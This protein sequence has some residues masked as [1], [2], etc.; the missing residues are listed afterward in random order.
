MR[1]QVVR[2]HTPADTASWMSRRYTRRVGPSTAC[3][4]ASALA[5]VRS[6]TQGFESGGLDVA[7]RRGTRDKWQKD[8]KGATLSAD[9]WKRKEKEKKR[10][11]RAQQNR[12]TNKWRGVGGFQAVNGLFFTDPSGTRRTGVSPALCDGVWQKGQRRERD[13]E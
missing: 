5:V 8:G 12:E 9:E 13:A 7:A 11:R 2:L 3:N 6:S 4:H 10:L 1:V